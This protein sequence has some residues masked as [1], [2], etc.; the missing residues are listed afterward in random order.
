[1]IRAAVT[2]LRSVVIRFV[3]IDQ[4]WSRSICS[5]SISLNSNAMFYFVDSSQFQVLKLCD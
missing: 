2:L 1:M 5:V 4:I 3:N